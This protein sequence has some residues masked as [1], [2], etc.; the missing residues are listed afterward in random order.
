MSLKSVAFVDKSN[1][2][3][4]ILKEATLWQEKSRG[5]QSAFCNLLVRP[6]GSEDDG[7]E[8]IAE[9]EM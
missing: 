8:I 3:I 6:Q 5:K 2:S 9:G 1:L 4:S 7:L